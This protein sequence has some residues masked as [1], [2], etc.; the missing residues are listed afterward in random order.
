M[1]S[2]ILGATLAVLAVGLAT[3]LVSDYRSMSKTSRTY[4][5]SAEELLNEMYRAAKWKA[6]ALGVTLMFGIALFSGHIQIAGVA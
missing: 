6:F 2:L 5:A 4:G 1:Y 3:T